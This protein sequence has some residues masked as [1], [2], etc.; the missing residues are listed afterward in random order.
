[1]INWYPGFSSQLIQVQL[2]PLIIK[3]FKSEFILVGM[4]MW[5]LGLER[6][7]L[8]MLLL[9]VAMGPGLR[10]WAEY[11]LSL[12]VERLVSGLFP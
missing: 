1:M 7:L 12:R 8:V 4:L 9:S 5:M 11:P 2:L 10:L 3:L 6:R